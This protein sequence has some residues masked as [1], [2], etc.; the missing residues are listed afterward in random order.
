ML[1]LGLRRTSDVV[2]SQEFRDL[3]KLVASKLGELADGILSG[4]VDI[5]PYR[6]NDA[7]PCSRCD[8]R[9]VCR[10]DPAINRYNVLNTISRD[11]VISK[12]T[13]RG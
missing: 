11:E 7:S 5:A 1:T 8:Y 2:E 9:S 12:G 13:E 6:L 4:K 3:L 10:F